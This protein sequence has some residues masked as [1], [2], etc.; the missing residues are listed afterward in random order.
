MIATIAWVEV[1]KSLILLVVWA[2]FGIA[3]HVIGKTKGRAVTGGVLGVL[4]GFIGLIII[5]LLPKKR[6]PPTQ[7]TT[8]E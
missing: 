6:E 1:G 3:G 2:A 8:A 5:A 7:P 4:L